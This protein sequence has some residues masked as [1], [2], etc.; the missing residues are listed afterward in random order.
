MTRIATQPVAMIFIACIVCAVTILCVQRSGSE[1]QGGSKQQAIPPIDD[2]N[3]EPQESN[4]SNQ[5]PNNELGELLADIKT[6]VG[7]DVLEGTSL[8]NADSKLGKQHFVEA[9]K[10]LPAIPLS[11]SLVE[12]TTTSINIHDKAESDYFTALHSASRC[13]EDRAGDLD[14]Q[15]LHSDARRLRR[16]ARKLRQEACLSVAS[17]S[18]GIKTPDQRR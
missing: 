1:E 10:E 14:S 7:I 9:I 17:E 2:S 8:E 4:Q 15:H 11:T 12:P 16:L 18:H 13:L 6:R 5:N 3:T